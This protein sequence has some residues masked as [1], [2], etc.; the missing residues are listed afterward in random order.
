MIP[1]FDFQT[2]NKST[3]PSSGGGSYQFWLQE[4]GYT[5]HAYAQ[6]TTSTDPATEAELYC[7]HEA[8]NEDASVWAVYLP[9]L[10]VDTECLQFNIPT[11]EKAK[12]LIDTAQQLITGVLATLDVAEAIQGLWSRT[13]R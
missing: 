4:Q 1:A 12:D 10:G 8:E 5:F 2:G 3:L 11:I 9:E 6:L 13:N 7:K